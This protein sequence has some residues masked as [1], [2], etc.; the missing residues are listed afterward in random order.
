MKQSNTRHE[1]RSSI[2]AGPF[3]IAYDSELFEGKL[4]IRHNASHLVERLTPEQ[5]NDLIKSLSATLGVMK[6]C[7]EHRW[8]EAITDR[9][10]NNNA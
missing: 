7:N 5:V 4:S 3:T 8:H 9:F 2:P 6:S 10:G 1:F